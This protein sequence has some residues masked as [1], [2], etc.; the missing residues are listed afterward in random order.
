MS[1]H[2]IANKDALHSIEDDLELSLYI[3]VWTGLK[4][5]KTTLTDSARSLLITQIFDSDEVLDIGGSS[6]SRFLAA[7]TD[8]VSEVFV[9][10]NTLDTLIK[11]LIEFFSHRY[12]VVA[13]REQQAFN[14]FQDKYV[15]NSAENMDDTLKELI[16]SNH[17]YR[18][19]EGM[20]IMNSPDKIH[21]HIIENYNLHLKDPGW[22]SDDVAV[23]QEVLWD[24]QYKIWPAYTKSQLPCRVEL[25]PNGKRRRLE[26][27][28][29]VE[30]PSP[31]TSLAGLATL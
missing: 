16:M 26:P 4:Y 13:S 23:E 11:E 18:K 5:S 7:Q 20:K 9:G 2:L 28:P 31:V 29:D 24:K 3:T 15:L 14:N 19:E 27:L 25:M 17:V 1:A 10:C 6:K 21:D 30:T 12:S 8:F 22:P